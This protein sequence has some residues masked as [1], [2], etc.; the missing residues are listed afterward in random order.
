MLVL[1]TVAALA[2]PAWIVGSSGTA[3]V[4]STQVVLT[5]GG[6]LTTLAWA[7]RVTSADSRLGLL[8]PVPDD[9]DIE[10]ATG[11]SPDFLERYELFTAPRV[12]RITCDDLVSREYLYT[13]PG[14]RTT[15]EPETVEESRDAVDALRLDGDWLL[16]RYDF[17]LVDSDPDSDLLT[18]DAW[19]EQEG[20]AVPTPTP[21]AVADRAATGQ[22][23]LAIRADLDRP[24]S[25]EWLSPIRVSYRQSSLRLP[26]DVGALSGS[27]E[28]ELVLYTLSNLA[29]GRGDIA[30]YPLTA[31]ESECMVAAGSPADWYESEL[32][33]IADQP[34]PSWVLEYSGI[35]TTCQP[36]TSPPLEDI[37]VR[38]FGFESEAD[39]A[40][41]ARARLR[42]PAATVDPEL[43]VRFTAS[44]TDDVTRY[45][46]SRREL[47]FAYPL[48]GT[49]FP[50]EPSVCED[51]APPGLG[52]GGCTT[53]PSPWAPAFL[54]IGGLVALRRRRTAAI[55]LALLVALPAVAQERGRLNAVPTVELLGGVAG[56]TTP[57]IRVD[58][59]PRAGPWPSNPVLTADAIWS[60]RRWRAGTLGLRVGGS[61]FAGRAAP[62]MPEAPVRFGLWEPVVGLTMRHG[63]FSSRQVQPFARW[64]A[65]L[66]A[67]IL[68]SSAWTPHGLVSFCAHAGAGAWVG[69]DARRLA[70]ETRISAVPRTDAYKVTF[71]PSTRIPGWLFLPGSVTVSLH[72]GVAFP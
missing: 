5:R 32:T 37:E 14:C 57:R 4:D 69:R 20:F 46:E 62:G 30:N 54:L 23:W 31:I 25:G 28:Q 66:Q 39:L 9:I 50:D 61:A 53:A 42:Y 35:P 51:L 36:C 63:S 65:G 67:S 8:L 71:H 41:L 48:C 17:F 72:A 59:A 40:W 56:W 34:L 1:L 64:G 38:D 6:D 18:W 15:P 52:G 13:A 21:T 68:D 44:A 43:I 70:L 49:G 16:S 24:A 10:T 55:V 60:I 22:L 45:I 29:E 19:L 3:T 7:P 27:G 47:E 12:D 11:I 2:T 58:G 26:L 33:E